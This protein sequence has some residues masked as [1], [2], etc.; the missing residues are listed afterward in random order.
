MATLRPS[1]RAG[2]LVY[3]V[4]KSSRYNTKIKFQAVRVEP[5]KVSGLGVANAFKNVADAAVDAVVDAH[6]SAADVVGVNTHWLTKNT[7]TINDTP[8]NFQVKY[9]TS[10]DS[11]YRHDKCQFGCVAL[12]VTLCSLQAALVGV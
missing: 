6:W 5:P 12:Q 8:N 1:N 4:E 9:S 7:N 3:P 10:V 2:Q 11:K